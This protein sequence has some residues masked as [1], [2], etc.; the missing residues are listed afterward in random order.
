MKRL[1][2]ILLV[3]PL[4]VFSQNTTEYNDN[5]AQITLKDASI[6]DTKRVFIIKG[7]KEERL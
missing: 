3:L 6:I 2:L 4:F 5:Y 7:E 1:I